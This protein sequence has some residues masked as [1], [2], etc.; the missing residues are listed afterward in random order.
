MKQNEL[1]VKLGV[2]R[3]QVNK[4][5]LGQTNLTLRTIAELA[6]AM[7]KDIHFSL[8]GPVISVTKN[9]FSERPEV[10]TD[11]EE[12]SQLDI[13]ATPTSEDVVKEIEYV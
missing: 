12:S 9:Y 13:T 8:G 4:Q 5:L 7:D 3:S 11:T 10:E 2:N 1:A 6:W